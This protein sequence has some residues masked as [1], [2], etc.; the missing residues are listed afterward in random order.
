MPLQSL[1][2]LL[3][4][5]QLGASVIFLGRPQQVPGLLDYQKKSEALQT[6]AEDK[7]N[8][9]YTL[10]EMEIPLQ[11]AGVIQEPMVN[12]GLKFLRREHQGEKIY[13]VVNHTPKK[14]EGLIPLGVS[15]KEVLIMDPLTGKTGKAITTH[16]N[17]IT[18]VKL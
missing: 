8:K 7:I 6:L 10:K 4:L 16:Y 13:F 15:D 9:I 5:R 12:K 17:K 11:K 14:I 2:K 3:D 18:K 1:K